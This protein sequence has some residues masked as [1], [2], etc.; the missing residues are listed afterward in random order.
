MVRSIRFLCQVTGSHSHFDI[1]RA[2]S[3][4]LGIR[5]L[6][7][8]LGRPGRA[9]RNVGPLA[10]AGKVDRRAHH[11]TE[12]GGGH[13]DIEVRRE[14]GVSMSEAQPSWRPTCPPNG[15]IH[16]VYGFVWLPEG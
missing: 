16:V 9:Q 4:S 11:G 5:F 8:T 3:A 7:R 13:G 2:A 6:P 10:Q 1:V 14:G 12:S 15:I